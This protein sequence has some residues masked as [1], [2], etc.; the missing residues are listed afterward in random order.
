MKNREDIRA[1]VRNMLDELIIRGPY[2]K[3]HEFIQHGTQSVYD[4]CVHVAELCCKISEKFHLRVRKHAMIRGALLHD[5][6]LYDWHEPVLI[7]K[8]HGFTH[9]KKAM[10]NAVKHYHISEREKNMI[11]R[12]MF[13]LTLIPPANLE[14]WVLCIADKICTVQEVL[15][16]RKHGAYRKS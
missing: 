14:A 8:I 12:H 1:D 7:H 15:D 4:H 2:D 9:P 5:F 3:N 16:A 11:R 10:E 6:F 13:P